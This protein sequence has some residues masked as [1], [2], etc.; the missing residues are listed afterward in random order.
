MLEKLRYLTAGESHGRALVSVIEGIP[1]NLSLS[2]VEIDKDLARRQKGYGRGGRMKI[3]SDHAQIISGVR[4]GKTLGSP[5][6]LLIENKDWENWRETMSPELRDMGH[7]ARGKGLKSEDSEL[8]TLNSKLYHV[9]RPRPG[10]A[11]LAGA[12]KYNTYDIRNILERSSARETASRVAAGAVA[13]KFLAEFNIRIISYVTEIGGVKVQ[14]TEH[15]TQNTDMKRMSFLYK[16]TEASPVRCPD[17]EAEKKIINKINAAMKRGDTLG[18]MF[19][20]VVLGAPAGLGSYTQWD[21]KLDA[22]LAFALMSIQA[23]KGV[24]I[25]LGLEMSRRAG[26]E[27]MDEIYYKGSLRGQGLTLTPQ[28]AGFYRK[29]NN[30]GGIEGG[31]SNGMPLIIRAAMKPIPTLKTPLSSVDII[32]KKPFSAAYERSDVCAVPAASVI[33]EAVTAIVIADSFLSKFGGDSME[34]V[35]RNYEGYIKQMREF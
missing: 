19:E 34:E 8:L 6:A 3:E 20:V 7:G 10:H 9:T 11:D 21:R 4:H 32:T 15:R 14:N 25:G 31:M 29:T 28:G 27:V 1:S 18:G 24:E 16:K 17:K 5:I 2:A 30:A 33:G 26:S 12:L 22:K 13:K 23:I 35:R